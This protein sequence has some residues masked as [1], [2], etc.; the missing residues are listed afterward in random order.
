MW[1]T[2]GDVYL[3]KWI[4]IL[5]RTSHASQ[6]QREVIDDQIIEQ[7]ARNLA[8]STGGNATEEEEMEVTK[9]VNP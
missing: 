5:A 6:C 7:E 9:Q 3:G 2:S 8:T 4:V 1:E